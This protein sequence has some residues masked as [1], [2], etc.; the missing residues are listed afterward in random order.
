[1]GI[2]YF[3]PHF[4]G[5]LFVARRSG[6]LSVLKGLSI[7][8][9]QRF[10][11]WAHDHTSCGEWYLLQGADSVYSMFW[12][13]KRPAS[14]ALASQNRRPSTILS[15]SCERVT[16]DGLAGFFVRVGQVVRSYMEESKEE[17]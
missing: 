11:V 7:Y 13:S 12:F 10:A 4:G 8:R 9:W 16:A 5:F 3:N 15:A 1:M 14:G 6:V 17:K 2:G